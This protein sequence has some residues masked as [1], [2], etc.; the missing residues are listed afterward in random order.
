MRIAGSLS[1]CWYPR[2]EYEGQ[3]RGTTRDFRTRVAMCI[4]VGTLKKFVISM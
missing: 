1:S 4:E 3:I 2:K